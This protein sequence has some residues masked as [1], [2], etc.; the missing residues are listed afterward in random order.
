MLTVV[1]NNAAGYSLTVHR[2]VFTPA[3][4]PLGLSSTAPAGGSLGPSLSG[5][6]RASIPVVPAADLVIGTTS[7]Q[8]AAGGDA[9]PTSVGFTG[10]LPVVAPGRYSATVTYTLIG[11]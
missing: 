11:R 1:S 5:G 10:P 8:S 3:D 2:S 4:L 7:A 6:Q 9:W